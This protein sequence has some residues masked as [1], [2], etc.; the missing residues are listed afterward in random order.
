MKSVLVDGKKI[1]ILAAGEGIPFIYWG[2]QE[3]SGDYVEKVFAFLKENVENLSVTL[4]AY[5][6]EDWNAEFS[7]WK[8]P[9]VFR[10]T[11]E[12][13]GFAGEGKKTLEWLKN[14]CIPYVEK[15]VTG[16]DERY[17]VGYSL[18]GLFSIWAFYESRNFRGC[19][20]G[21]GSLWFP[22]W[23][24]YVQNAAAPEDSRIY[25]SLGGKE[26]KTKNPV[27]ATIG[28]AT[29]EMKTQ[30]EKDAGVTYSKLEW[31]PGGHFADPDIRMAKGIL[32]LLEKH[33]L[34]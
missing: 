31:N 5:E 4:V 2:V 8:A 32:W 28:D 11:E 30:L 25:L 6:A 34:S 12:D 10:R 18:A 27:M 1:H 9:A 7:P 24:E 20:S 33:H 14:S 23:K 15:S 3:N 13:P 17:L 29:R 22:D 19:A 16:R 26:E 21:S